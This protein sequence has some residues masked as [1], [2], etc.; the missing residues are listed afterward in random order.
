MPA[1][2]CA[3]DPV[4]HLVEDCDHSEAFSSK[5][6]ME[7]FNWCQHIQSDC[8][9]LPISNIRK[10]D[11]GATAIFDAETGRID[12]QYS[13][14]RVAVRQRNRLQRRHWSHLRVERRDGLVHVQ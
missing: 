13:N 3:T 8:S 12:L 6:K 11:C 1:A 5:M 9:Q 7:Q 2:C 4:S 10:D 14:K